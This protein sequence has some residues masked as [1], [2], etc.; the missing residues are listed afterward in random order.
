MRHE[1]KFIEEKTNGLPISTTIRD[2]LLNSNEFRDY[3]VKQEEPH[4][5][6]QPTYMVG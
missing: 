2:M 5:D 3:V 1:Q 6:Q 4:G